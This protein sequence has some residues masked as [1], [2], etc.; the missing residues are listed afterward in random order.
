MVRPPV[1]LTFTIFSIKHVSN[2]TLSPSFILVVDLDSGI[3]E[4]F[5]ILEVYFMKENAKMLLL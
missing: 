3:P 4:V 2:T 5:E 1:R